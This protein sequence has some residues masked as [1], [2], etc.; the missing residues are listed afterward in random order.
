MSSENTLQNNVK[1]KLFLDN[2]ISHTCNFINTDEDTRITFT[3]YSHVTKHR[4]AFRLQT[5]VHTIKSAAFK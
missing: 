3:Q 1:Y 2:F 5:I 4:A